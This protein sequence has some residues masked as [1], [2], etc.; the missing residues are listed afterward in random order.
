MSESVQQSRNDATQHSVNTGAAGNLTSPGLFVLFAFELLLM[1]V[2]AWYYLV[3]RSS[4]PLSSTSIANLI[5][6]LI[7]LVTA[8]WGTCYLAMS[9]QAAKQWNISLSRQLLA[10]AVAS[11]AIL[12]GVLLLNITSAFA[13]NHP[14][15]DIRS[16]FA[17]SSNSTTAETPEALVGD[18][19]N[20]KKWF[21]MSCITCHGPTGDGVANAAPSLRSS[22]FLKTATD[23]SIASLIRNGR[24]ANDPANKSGKVMPA[25]GGNPFLDEAK[26]AD[27]VALLQ[28][29]ESQFGAA[30]SAS[31][32]STAN[33]DLSNLPTE[34][35]T[36]AAFVQKWTHAELSSLDVTPSEESVAMGMQA[37][38]K[39]TCNKCHMAAV[40]GQ[41]LG[42]T[43]DQIVKKYPRQKLLEHI[44]TPSKEINEK[45]QAHNFLLLDGQTISGV[46][47]TESDEK[48]E[49][50]TDTLKPDQLTT[51]LVDDIDEQLKSKLS[52]MPEGLLDV[53]T[54]EEI[55]GLVTYVDA[56]GNQMAASKA[57]QLNRWVVPSPTNESA[58]SIS[59][60][61]AS[62]NQ[63]SYSS[64]LSIQ[65][66]AQYASVFLWLFV[67]A[68]S[69][70]VLH[71]L[72]VIGLGG[73]V[74][75]HRELQLSSGTQA[76]LGKQMALFW[77]IGVA[78]LM[79]WF[80]LFF[81]IG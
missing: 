64:V 40:E 77:T 29:L 25:K 81:L 58:S 20:G 23:A 18:A 6:G 31:Q 69:V 27:L 62:S 33:L 55:A 34:S 4:F 53:L 59:S 2:V 10:I 7:A 42:P 41:E 52:T 24:A 15:V 56:V 50:M 17:Q 46:I 80:I 21:G 48:I 51:I 78:W 73:A 30:K 37:F 35:K 43:L 71:F 36:E 75:L 26:I 38:V 68:T 63:A 44:V 61:L 9:H 45:Y 66:S 60:P 11:G 5:W 3:N 13:D 16:Q 70:L 74:V 14:C 39:A 22:E 1:G 79:L 72:W 8:G 12:L 49:L 67:S 32:T 65:D 54:K 76:R 47:V 57:L 28:D 19:S